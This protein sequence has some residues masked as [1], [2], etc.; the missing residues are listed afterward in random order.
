MNET[1]LLYV[2]QNIMSNVGTYGQTILY[3]NNI[4][5]IYVF[6][7]I[8]CSNGIYNIYIFIYGFFL[9]MCTR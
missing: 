8:I 7:Y 5:Q 9:W 6:I 2:F 4:I 1:N 3:S